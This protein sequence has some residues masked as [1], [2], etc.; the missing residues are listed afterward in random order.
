MLWAVLERKPIWKIMRWAVSDSWRLCWY[1][2]AEKICANR[3]C[4]NALQSRKH[5]WFSLLSCAATKAFACSVLGRGNLGRR[6]RRA[7]SLTTLGTFTGLPSRTDDDVW[8]SRDSLN[9]LHFLPQKKSRTSK[10]DSTVHLIAHGNLSET[11][12]VEMIGAESGRVFE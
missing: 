2:V 3:R 7:F 12:V 5:R 11:S 6:Q 9:N 10:F 1:F 4:G 8:E